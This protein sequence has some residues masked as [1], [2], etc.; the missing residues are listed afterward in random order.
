[1][2]ITILDYNI[3][4]FHHS[5]HMFLFKTWFVFSNLSTISTSAYKFSISTTPNHDSENTFIAQS[6]DTPSK[7]K[8]HHI[9]N[10]VTR[11]FLYSLY[12]SRVCTLIRVSLSGLGATM[13]W[14]LLLLLIHTRKTLCK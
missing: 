3:L 13:Y 14:N 10:K 6:L 9:T 12:I 4:N 11:Y 8:K 7:S 2:I 1:M 5:Y